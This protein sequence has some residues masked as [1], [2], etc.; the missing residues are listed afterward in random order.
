M[1]SLLW[2]VSG[3]A[4]KTARVWEALTGQELARL[5]HDESVLSVAFSAD[6]KSVIFGGVA[7]ARTWL[8]GLPQFTAFP[9]SSG[10]FKSLPGTQHAVFTPGRANDLQAHWQPIHRAAWD[11]KRRQ[12]GQVEGRGKTRQARRISG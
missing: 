12:P 10:T 8:C 5:T 11:G 4:D 1:I 2:L 3:S 7:R 9:I 6:E